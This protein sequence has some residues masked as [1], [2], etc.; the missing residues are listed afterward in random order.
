MLTALEI[1]VMDQV[2]RV[3]CGPENTTVGEMLLAD[4]TT[5]M[6]KLR[7]NSNI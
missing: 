2:V 7:I 5:R 6:W 3:M 4:D 1:K